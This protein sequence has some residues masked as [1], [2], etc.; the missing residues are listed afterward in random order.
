MPLYSLYYDVSVP[1]VPQLTFTE[2]VIFV[3]K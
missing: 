1:Q 2:T 3:N